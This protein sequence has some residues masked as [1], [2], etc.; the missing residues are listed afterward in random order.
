MLRW[1]GD[2]GRASRARF[3][4]LDCDE[5]NEVLRAFYRGL[6]FRE[7]GRRDLTDG[8]FSVTLFEKGL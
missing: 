8:L 1:A 2:R 3:L 6:G 5:S 4:R 7:V